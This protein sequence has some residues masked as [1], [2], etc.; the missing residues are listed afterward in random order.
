MEKIRENMIK[1][2]AT[3]ANSATFLG[4][5]NGNNNSSSNTNNITSSALQFS[6]S[7]SSSATAASIFDTMMMMP[8]DYSFGGDQKGYSLGLLDLLDG[9]TQDFGASSSLFDW[10]QF[11]APILSDHHHHQQEEQPL[12]SPAS[13]VPESSEVLNNPA[14]PNSSSIS[15]SSNEAANDSSQVV[16]AAEENDQDQDQD[17]N[18]KQLKPKKKNQKKQREQRFA[19]MTKSEVDHLDDGYRWR[20]YG[21]KAVKNSPYPRSYYR[22][23]SAGCGVKKRV[24]RSSEDNTIVV[25]T[26]EGQHTH[27]SPITPRGSIG[28]LS[29][30]SS[31]AAI[32]AA[33]NSSFVLPQTH[34]HHH[35]FQQN[36][37]AY[38]YTSSPS[39]NITTSDFIT[40]SPSFVH[41]ERRF[42]HSPD[43]LVRDHGLLQDIVPSQMREKSAEEHN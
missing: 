28:F 30:N 35:Q 17:K 25:T 22:C 34:H 14:T 9:N 38:M 2:E 15:S 4:E 33:A 39:L 5:T 1:M 27:Q 40:P 36:Q 11:Q 19:F 43:S 26:Y 37:H 32:F 16:K 42:C 29:D 31:S 20:K 18:K 8:C 13:T 21:Q 24:E 10:F 12:P 3:P 6:S 7:S 23:T 41:Q